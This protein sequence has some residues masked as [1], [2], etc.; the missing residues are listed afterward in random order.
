M[1]TFAVVTATTLATRALDCLNS[2]RDHAHK[3]FTLVGVNNGPGAH[4]V[5]AFTFDITLREPD[6]LGTV[7]AF[8]HGVN[9]LLAWAEPPDIIACLHDDLR[10][11]EEGWDEKVIRHFERHPACGLL[12]FGGA[13]GLGSNDLYRTPY[14]PMQLA[15]IGFRS[16]LDNAEIHGTRSLLPERVACLDGFSQIGRRSFWDGYQRMP[17]ASS[18]NPAELRYA[19]TDRPWDV[20]A[21]QLGITHH[22]Y[23]GMLGCLAARY[24]WDTWYLPIRGHHFGGRTAVGDAGYANW[25]QTQPAG[26]DQGFWQEAHRKGYDAFRDVLPLRV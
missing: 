6:Y 8:Q 17:G 20:L 15:R 7:P 13:I 1:T 18:T 21:N 22:F 5:D 2:W 26:S 10:I 24:H 14:D 16:N 11:D 19:L 12:G 23:D 9:H 4:D 3:D 25:A